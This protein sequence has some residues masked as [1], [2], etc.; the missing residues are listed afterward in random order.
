MSIFL[1]LRM[2]ASSLFHRFG[3]AGL[4][5]ALGVHLSTAYLGLV[6]LV[7]QHLTAAA[8]FI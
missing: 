2:Y 3:W 1:L 5:V 7:E 6:L 4:I 8:S